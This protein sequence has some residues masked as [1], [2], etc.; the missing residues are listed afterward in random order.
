MFPHP[1]IPSKTGARH[2][3]R[4]INGKEGINTGNCL[5]DKSA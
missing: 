2:N 3:K 1:I 4:D 5:Y